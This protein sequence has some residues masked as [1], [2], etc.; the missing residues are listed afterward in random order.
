MKVQEFIFR[1]LTPS[2]AVLY[3]IIE[4]SKVHPYKILVSKSDHKCSTITYFNVSSSFKNNPLKLPFPKSVL[5]NTIIL[6]GVP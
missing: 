3:R 6:S 2:V 1:G 4:F 5:V